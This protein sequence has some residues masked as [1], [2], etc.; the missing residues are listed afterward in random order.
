MQTEVQ[1]LDNEA[2]KYIKTRKTE[3]CNH[4]TLSKELTDLGY[5][6]K[7]GLKIDPPALSKFATDNGIRSVKQYKKGANRVK[8]VSFNQ[9]KVIAVIKAA[10][11]KGKDAAYIARKL[12]KEGFTTKRGKKWARVHVYDY[13]RLMRQGEKNTISFEGKPLPEMTPQPVKGTDDITAI[14]RSDLPK[15]LKLKILSEYL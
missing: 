7:T 1:V 3:G 13:I 2:L 6:T 15:H 9:Y 10:L 12:N 8:E 4:A 5:T 11:D 14:V